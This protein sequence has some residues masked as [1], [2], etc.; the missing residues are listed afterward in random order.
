MRP[1]RAK[2]GALAHGCIAVWPTSGLAK[3]TKH[4]CLWPLAAAVGTVW[5][6]ASGGC[7]RRR[8]AAALWGEAAASVTLC[9]VKLKRAAHVTG[10]AIELLLL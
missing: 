6:L 10:H 7:G 8:G 4:G 2:C 5:R 1:L 3:L 9:G